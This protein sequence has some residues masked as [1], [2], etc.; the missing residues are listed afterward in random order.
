MHASKFPWGVILE[1][2]GSK[3]GTHLNGIGIAK[4]TTLR[5]GD[6]VQIAY[7]QQFVY[8]ASD[9]TLPLDSLIM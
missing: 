8:L 1:D 6:V 4:P 9:A 7:A 3:N 2:L 5:D